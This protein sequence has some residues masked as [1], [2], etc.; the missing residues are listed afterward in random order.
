MKTA[1]TVTTRR[2]NAAT[3]TTR[4]RRRLNRRRAVLN[5]RTYST[6]AVLFAPKEPAMKPAV[7]ALGVVLALAAPEVVQ[8]SEQPRTGGVLRAAMIGEPPTLDL[9]TT[10]AV[11]VQQITWHIYETL[12]TY[13]RQYNAVPRLVDTHTVTDN[14]RTYLFKLRRG[15][16]F[17]NGKE[18]TSTDVIASLKRWGRLATPGK[19]A[20]R[21][22]E[23]VEA[24]DPYTV[25]MY[26]KEPSGSLLQVLARPN[27][28]AGKRVAYLDEILFVPVPDV[29][30]RLA[31]VETGEYHYAQQIKPDQ[32]E[33]VKTVRDV[34]PGIIKP[35]GWTTAVL[36]HKQW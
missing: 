10:T 16:K 24:K 7:L 19:A 28:P 20:W 34:V 30:V 29:A 6:V 22:V 5:T 9:H 11:I 33:R 4:R 21:N 12:F 13:D 18:L 8:P 35:A 14:G 26:L 3:R 2:T 23:G 15:V 32:Y 1:G 36:N 17:H 25:A 31:G 27:G